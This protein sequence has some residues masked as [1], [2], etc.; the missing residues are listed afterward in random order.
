MIDKRTKFFAL[1]AL[2]A[3]AL[4]P[5]ATDEKINNADWSLGISLRDVPIAVGVVYVILAILCGA[6]S[7]SRHMKKKKKSS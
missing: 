6:D 5:F 4:V 2:I 7:I 3:F 1:G